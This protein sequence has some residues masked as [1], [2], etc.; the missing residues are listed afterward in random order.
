[1]LLRVF[2]I[3]LGAPKSSKPV[4]SG[5]FENLDLF[6]NAT[7]ERFSGVAAM[8]FDSSSFEA[9]LSLTTR[10]VAKMERDVASP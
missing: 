4:F 8:P 6:G 10:L 1:L 9:S 7:S 3:R 5:Y 2:S